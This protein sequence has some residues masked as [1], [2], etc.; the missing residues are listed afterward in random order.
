[1]AFCSKCGKELAEGAQFCA[2]CGT[3]VGGAAVNDGTKRVQKFVGEIRKCPGCGAE[4]PAM[5]AVCPS[6]GHEL[7]N[8]KVSNGVKEFFEKLQ[9]FSFE[10]EGTIENKAYNETSR[11]RPKAWLGLLGAIPLLVG[12]CLVGENPV[13]GIIAILIGL[14]FVAA[15]VLYPYSA[16][17]ADKKRQ[18]FIENYVIPNDK[19]SIMEF[20]VLAG[21]QIDTSAN[22]VTGK[23]KLFWNKVWKTKINQVVIKAK[24]AL[25]GDSEVMEKIAAVKSEFNIK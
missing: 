18:Q 19:E 24:L 14:V 2:S 4:I 20:L 6:C 5:T 16:T 7:N 3:P 17:N 25:A 22:S 23:E 9:N 11:A 13:A 15:I 8:V 21:T 10:E 1:M 12:F